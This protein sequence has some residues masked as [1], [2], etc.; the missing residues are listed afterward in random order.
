MAD[1]RIHGDAPTGIDPYS[2]FVVEE[3]RRAGSGRP[4]SLRG[5]GLALSGL[6]FLGFVV[7]GACANLFSDVRFLMIVLDNYLPL[8]IGSFVVAI[9]GIVMMG[10]ARASQSVVLAGVG[11]AIFVLSFGFASSTAL[12]GYTGETISSA[13]LATAGITA[14]FACLG[15]A[16]PRIFERIQG[17]LFAA[18]LGLIVVEIVMMFM[19]VDQSWIDFAVIVVFCGFI[20]YDFHR[21]MEDE[22]TLVNAIFNA[23][24]LFL[25]IINVFLRVLSIFGRRN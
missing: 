22:P 19:G 9:V 20:A 10:R 18:L 15:V 8:T 6:V 12:I 11:Y 25:D 17:G 23:C 16:F 2:P 14:T 3:G 21:A 24:N 7:M 13:F 4:L 1:D 5:Y